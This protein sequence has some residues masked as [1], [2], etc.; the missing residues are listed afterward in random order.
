MEYPDFIARFYDVMY[1][2]IRTGQD[3][4]YYMNKIMASPGPVLEIGVGTGR[5]FLHALQKGAD[6]Y[7]VDISSEMLS[8]LK[9]NLRRRD[10]NRLYLQDAINLRIPLVFDL[11]IAP[12]RMFSH[13]LSIED[14]LQFLSRVAEHLKPG[15]T[16]IMD[17]FV[18]D[19][20]LIQEGLEN[21]N[22]FE[23]ED[24]NGL[25]V[26]RTV[27]MT[28]NL[29]DQVSTVKM[30]IF[31]GDKHFDHHGSFEFDMRYFFR[32]ELEHLIDRSPLNLH[33]IYGNFEE[34]ELQIHSKEF[35]VVCNK[36]I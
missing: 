14:Q 34:D 29:I 7:G 23:G 31:W 4:M 20:Q 11:I 8:V 6:I 28:S 27:T 36:P 16:F 9:Q 2:K 32:Y 18:P 13:V 1:E 15:G 26:K 22:D 10:F 17:V 19:L 21:V 5:F 25:K 24:K 12:F 30:D 33:R 35:L 3:H